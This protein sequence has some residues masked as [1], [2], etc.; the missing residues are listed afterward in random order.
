MNPY[1]ISTSTLLLL[2][3]PK[4][5]PNPVGLENGRITIPTKELS[6]YGENP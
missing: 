1:P 5:N 3:P 2:L 4:P 6:D